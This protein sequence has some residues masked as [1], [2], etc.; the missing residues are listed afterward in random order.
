MSLLQIVVVYA[1]TLA[2][3]FGAA[4]HRIEI[5]D[6]G[7][8]FPGLHYSKYVLGAFLGVTIIFVLVLLANAAGCTDGS[9]DQHGYLALSEDCRGTRRWYPILTDWQSGIGAFIGLLGL[10]WSTLLKALMDKAAE[11]EAAKDG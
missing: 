8:R 1:A 6:A 4:R 3:A 5:A 7:A 9:R 10:A 2:L 11:G